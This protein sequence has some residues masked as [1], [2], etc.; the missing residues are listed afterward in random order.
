MSIE[1]LAD[2][3]KNIFSDEVH[4]KIG[5]CLINKIVVFG[6][7]KLHEQFMKQIGATTQFENY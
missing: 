2:F 5:A 6:A 4:F 3:S 7:R 1:A